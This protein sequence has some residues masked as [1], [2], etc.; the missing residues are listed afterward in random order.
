VKGEFVVLKLKNG[1]IRRCTPSEPLTRLLAGTSHDAC[2]QQHQTRPDQQ[3]QRAR[4][5]EKRP[6]KHP[7]LLGAK[8]M[9][10]ALRIEYLR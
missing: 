10:P 8:L 2:K 3:R 7:K 5:R 9:I 4:E 6:Q 1:E